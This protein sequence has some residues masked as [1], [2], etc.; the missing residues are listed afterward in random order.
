[1]K[2]ND[3][4]AD[5]G[6]AGSLKPEYYATYA[7]YFVKYLR[8]MAHAGIPI[9]AITAQNEPVKVPA[10]YQGMFFP[11]P[12][13]A[14]FIRRYLRPALRVAELPT[15]IYGADES[16][17]QASYAGLENYQAGGLAGIAWHCY[18]GNPDHVM[19]TF[20]YTLQVI[21]ECAPSLIRAPIG[22]LIDN[23]FNDG[24]AAAALWNIALD[25]AGGPVVPPN[26]GCQGCAGLL[27]IRPAKHT[28][29]YNRAFYQLAQFGHFIEPG[30]RRIAATRLGHFDDDTSTDRATT[31]LHDVAIANPDG[32]NVLVLYNNSTHAQP[33]KVVWHDMS[34]IVSI[35]ASAT[36]TLRWR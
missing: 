4:L 35:P 30:A 15:K 7:Q 9:Y 26:S 22:A 20:A 14:Y 32:S 28:V 21:T 19:P 11:E 34:A 31:G 23:I 27:T 10:G 1:M 29:T 13:E 17:D 5:D 18:T 36:T 3:S 24:A 6:F 12:A 2:T 25:P 8:G 33:V 16:W